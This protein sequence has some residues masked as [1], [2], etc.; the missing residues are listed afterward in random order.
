MARVVP[1]QLR[2]YEESAPAEDRRPLFLEGLDAFL[3]VVRVVG[4]AA[5]GLDALVGFGREGVGFEGPN[6]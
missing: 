6:S 3:V 2:A 4:L 5:E 1:G